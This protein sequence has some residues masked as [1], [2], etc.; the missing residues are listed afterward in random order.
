MAEL[1]EMQAAVAE[2]PVVGS[3]GPVR[4]ANKRIFDFLL[5]AQRVALEQAIF[6][7][8]EWLDR[9]RNETHLLAEFTSKMAG[10]HSVSN[11]K[12]MFEECGQHQIDFI[13]RDCDRLFKHSQRTID[14]VSSLFGRPSED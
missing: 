12:T 3:T 5:R 13:R 9:A 4:H 1:F 10:A 7:A 8:E 2:N 6:V 11:V 14:A